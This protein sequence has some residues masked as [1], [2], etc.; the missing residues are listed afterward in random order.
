MKKSNWN[1]NEYQFPRFIA[2]AEAAGVFT[3]TV[4]ESM[5]ESMDLTFTEVC[6][7]ISRAKVEWEKIKTKTFPVTS[8]K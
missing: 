2:E 1:R 3:G 7:I 6:D 5:A 4:M 8:V